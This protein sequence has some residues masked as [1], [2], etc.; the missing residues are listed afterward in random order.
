MRRASAILVALLGLVP[1]AL[2]QSVPTSFCVVGAGNGVELR[3]T[4]PALAAGVS[5]DEAGRLLEIH[6]RIASGETFRMVTQRE[7]LSWWPTE[8]SAAG[9]NRL[10]VAMRDKDLNTILEDWEFGV[11]AALAGKPPDPTTPDPT[12]GLHIPVVRKEVV[13]SGKVP[14]KDGV[15]VLFPD[16]AHPGSVL[17]LFEDSR[18]LYRLDLGTKVLTRLLSAADEPRL[19]EPIVDR[20]PADHDQLGYVYFLQ[21]ADSATRGYG[22]LVL[23]DPLRNGEL[24][25]AAIRG[26]DDDE[27]G[28]LFGDGKLYRALY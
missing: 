6:W 1:P 27:W 3:T 14:G 2:A 15:K 18:D 7:R 12:K 25:L 11:E 9:P 19:R 8:V 17:V 28:R 21:L 20:R 22:T 4:H 13:F 24:P 23:V 16:L 10:C 26:P 5:Y